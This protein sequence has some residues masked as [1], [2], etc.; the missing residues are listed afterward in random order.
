VGEVTEATVRERLADA[1]ALSWRLAA[2]EII[3]ADID[4]EVSERAR[5]LII[6]RVTEVTE[7]EAED[8]ES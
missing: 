5:E 4:S 8:D 2:D 3:V 6:Q 7:D 1:P